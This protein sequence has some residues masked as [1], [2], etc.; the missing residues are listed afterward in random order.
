MIRKYNNSTFSVKMTLQTAVY[1]CAK[2]SRFIGYYI[3][4]LIVSFTVLFF[5]IL[6]HFSRKHD[7]IEI[8]LNYRQD[9]EFSYIFLITLECII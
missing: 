1:S 5:K 9:F 7:Q 8:P 2:L 3:P 6:E 4:F